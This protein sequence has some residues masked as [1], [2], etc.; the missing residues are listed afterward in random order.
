MKKNNDM[1]EQ[2]FESKKTT[3]STIEKRLQDE[4]A[5]ERKARKLVKEIE[6]EIYVTKFMSTV[7][8]DD[9]IDK[10]VAKREQIDAKSSKSPIK[11]MMK[12]N[13]TKEEEEHIG[14]SQITNTMKGA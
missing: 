8:V 6:K 5:M 4:I 10:M 2:F 3:S 9:F 1:L 14:A 11:Q 12:S 13:Q 7:D